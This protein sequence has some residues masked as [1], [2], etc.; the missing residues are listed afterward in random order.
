MKPLKRKYCPNCGSP[1]IKWVIPQMWS[2]WECNECGYT[3]P[4]VIEDEE[5]AEEIRKNYL[6]IVRK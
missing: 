3:G 1:N 6:K 2:V 5:L 4:I